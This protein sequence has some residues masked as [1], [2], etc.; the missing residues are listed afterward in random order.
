MKNSPLKGPFQQ[1][2]YT[3]NAHREYISWTYSKN[4][5]NTK[6]EKTWWL[7]LIKKLMSRS[8]RDI[9]RWATIRIVSR[10]IDTV[11]IYRH[12]VSSLVGS[13]LISQPL[14]NLEHMFQI[15]L[16][17]IN[18]VQNWLCNWPIDSSSKMA[19]WR[20][21]FVGL[22]FCIYLRVQ[23]KQ[24]FKAIACARKAIACARKA[25]AWPRKR[26]CVRT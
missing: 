4:S 22:F 15:I 10:R 11:S 16:L 24:M 26:Y 3:N 18:I 13:V 25:I 6:I 2:F 17:F 5:S 19:S 9:S 7:L 1:A 20:I 23:S 8:Y 21:W 14:Y 12:I